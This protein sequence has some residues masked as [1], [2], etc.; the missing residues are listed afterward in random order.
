M[1]L[2]P[3]SAAWPLRLLTGCNGLGERQ[4]IG[5]VHDEA[6]VAVIFDGSGRQKAA[7]GL[8]MKS[9]GLLSISK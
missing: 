8:V 1:T 2:R 5:V 3:T 9:D 7:R 6:G 4:P